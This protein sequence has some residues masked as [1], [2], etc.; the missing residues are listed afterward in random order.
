[1]SRTRVRIIVL[2]GIVFSIIR[3]GD[4]DRSVATIGRVSDG[5]VEVAS[6]VLEAAGNAP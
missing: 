2:V 6:G 5:S 1:M 3:L 4:R